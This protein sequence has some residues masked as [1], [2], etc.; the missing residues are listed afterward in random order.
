MTM[1]VTHPSTRKVWS[2]LLQKSVAQAS[3]LMGSP[4]IKKVK[5]NETI[6]GDAVIVMQDELMA[7]VGQNKGSG[8]IINFD[9]EG[10]LFGYPTAGDNVIS[11]STKLSLFTDQIQINQDRF[12]VQNDGKFADG[13]VPYDFLDR[14]RE[15]LTNEFWKHYWDERLIIKAS[16]SLGSNTWYTVD[17]TK[18]TSS[19]RNVNGSVASDG[20]DLRSPTSTR[21]I[22]GN[23]RAG[24]S[25]ITTG[26]KLSLDIIDQAILQAIRPSANSTL[27]RVVPTLTLN[28]R[29]SFVLLAD[30][31]QLQGMNASTSERFYDLQRAQIQGGGNAKAFSDWAT[32]FYRSPMGV[33]VY[34]VAH[35]N[36]VKFS[37]AL[38]GGQKLCR[39][40]LLGQGALRVALGRESKEVGAYSWHDRPVD[41]GNQTRVTTGVVAGIQ[42]PAYNTTETNST[43]EDYAVVAI[44]TYANW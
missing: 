9:L 36:L 43:R 37:A 2:N 5:A 40:L 21:I 27:K 20:N 7:G 42:K 12:S 32:Y 19:A 4:L 38:S 39:A 25:T 28:G 3:F 6:P 14:A 23:G 8:Y 22:Y 15:R 41:E 1:T 24:Q 44:D 16:G 29:P 34:I 17:A 31:V 26:D 35:P 11:G 33:D 10:P 13:L 30:Y 18:A